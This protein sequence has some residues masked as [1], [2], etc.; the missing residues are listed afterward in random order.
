MSDFQ[1]F[2][3]ERMLSAWEH[4][5]D[6]NLSESAAH[7]MTVAELIGA[8]A[9]ERLGEFEIGYPQVSGSD[10]LRERIA[11]LYSG[12]VRDNVLVTVGA[13]EANYLAVTS[14]LAPGDEIVVMRPN[15]MQI[16]GAA[17]NRG[18]TVKGFRLREDRDWAPDLDELEAAVGPK[19]RAIAVCN[20]NNPT[21]RILR[22]EEMQAIVAAAERVGAWVLAD[23][24]Y[25]GAE[26]LSEEETPSFYGQYDR[27]LAMGSL[28]KAYGLPGLRIGWTVG[29]E[30]VLGEM[31]MRHDYV[32]LCHTALSDHLACTALAPEVRPRILE[33]TRRFVREGYRVLETWMNAHPGR[34]HW[35]PPDASAVAFVRYALE[36]GSAE[37]VERLRTEKSVLIVPGEHFGLEYHLRIS[38]GFPRDYLAGGLDRIHELLS[39]LER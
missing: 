37:L 27:V 32:A 29:P 20:P 30:R 11:A 4:L 31:S 12:A 18:V 14:L 25:A 35:T 19:T 21:G 2:A 24:V 17:Q 8:D 39:D 9:L 28:S 23:E 36:I 34:F 15:Y 10:T 5:V 3:M 38:F 6:Y 22:G 7:P 1:P 16:W 33:R 13:S 26:R